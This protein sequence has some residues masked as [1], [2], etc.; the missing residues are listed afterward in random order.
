[1]TY[2]IIDGQ[3]FTLEEYDELQKQ[4]RLEKQRSQEEAARLSRQLGAAYAA[5]QDHLRRNPEAQQITDERAVDQQIYE[6]LRRNLQRADKAPRCTAVK[7]DG[8]VCGSPKI[9]DH[10]YCYAHFQMLQGRAKKLVLPALEDA[11][12]IQM[13]VMRVQRALI[14][15]EISEKK[16]GLL[17]YSIQ[18]AA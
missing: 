4:R 13:A 14:D 5:L 8:T 15:D 3:K 10:V 12:A 1:M 2:W 16:A 11:N 7:E 17:L 9:K 18:I 6:N